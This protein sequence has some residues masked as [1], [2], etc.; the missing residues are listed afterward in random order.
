ME[1]LPFTLPAWLPG[2]FTVLILAASVYYFLRE[3]L[4]PDLTSLLALLALLIA[5]VL[6]PQEAF[7][8]FSHP[9]TISVAAVL[10]LS[11]GLERT[12]AL[13]FLARR[14]VGPFGRSEFLLSMLLM[15]VVAGLSAFVNNTAAVAVFI[16]IVLELSRRS[17]IA[18]SRLLMPMAFAATLG[19][20]CT[21]IGTSTNLIGHSV[22]RYQG[23]AGFTMFE[24]GQVGVPMLLAGLAYLLIAGRF[25]LPKNQSGLESLPGRSGPYLSELVLS[26]SSSWIDREIKPDS[27]RRD[28]DLEL[29]EVRRDS[30]KVEKP[31]EGE[32]PTRYAAGDHVRVRG[33]VEQVLALAAREGFDLHR[34]GS[35]TLEESA[36]AEA[37]PEEADG[38][39]APAEEEA[40][41][42]ERQESEPPRKS[43]LPLA[44]FVILPGCPLTGRTL[45]GARFAER[46]DALV[47]ALHRPGEQ[48]SDRPNSTPIRAGDVIVAE[49]EV[50]AL[51]ALAQTNGFLLVGS[52]QRPAERPHKVWVALLT[53]VGVVAAVSL[54]VLPIVTAASAGCAILMLTGCLTPR[55]AYQAIDWRIIFLLAGALALAT[56]LEKTGL[57]ASLATGLSALTGVA[58]PVVVM[59]AFFMATSVASQL[60]SNAG[61]VALLG[62]LA[63]S[64]AAQMGINPMALL[65]AVTLGASCSFATPIGYQTNLMVYGPGGYRFADYLKVGLPL[66]IILTI[67]AIWLI[68]R[69]W[70]LVLP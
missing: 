59:A 64:S 50:V 23:Y 18:A 67:I 65:V 38:D 30:R 47:L 61:T 42:E 39:G 52:L 19:G 37:V 46:Y 15:V 35:W 17:G 41:Q 48:L 62:P 13:T 58:G 25:F 28:F 16:P 10:V 1:L 60:M 29:V 53:I 20:L 5:G 8:G 21:L 14:L 66:N 26:A 32:P 51:Q 3:K 69:Y 45:K 27:L 54:G 44:E 12:G 40:P 34:P 6:T 24:L 63:I 70:P 56:A 33:P 68:P 4:P 57:T 49:G 36:Q 22:A 7:S 11:A 9:A 2:F 55:E 31:A 43:G